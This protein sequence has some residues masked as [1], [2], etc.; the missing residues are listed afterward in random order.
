MVT[1]ILVSALM[2]GD[3]VVVPQVRLGRDVDYKAA[4]G[5]PLTAA[6]YQKFNPPT[7]AELRRAFFDKNPDGSWISPEYRLSVRS[8]RGYGEWTS[9]FLKDGREAIERPDNVYFDGKRNLWIAEGGKVSRVDLPPSGWTL[10][11]D[12]PTGFPSITSRK[13]KDAEKVFG[14]D[15]SYFLAYKNGL[16]AVLRN[17]ALYDYGPFVVY[18]YY[19]PGDRYSA[20]GVRSPRRPEQ[21]IENHWFSI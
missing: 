11:Y 5:N 6:G 9:T 14:D 21:E 18:A 7:L 13:R 17:F 12:K 1:E 10:G 4:N 16:R 3:K 20:V 8:T 19:G 2:D 15:T